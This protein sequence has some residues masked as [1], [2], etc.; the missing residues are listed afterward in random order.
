MECPLLLSLPPSQL[1]ITQDLELSRLGSPTHQPCG[2]LCISPGE[3][4]PGADS[5][6]ILW[7]Q[8]WDSQGHWLPGRGVAGIGQ[9]LASLSGH[10]AEEMGAPAGW[11]RGIFFVC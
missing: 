5:E 11:R 8:G 10:H 2:P 1:G 9:Y 6:Q 7:K 4:L 3:G